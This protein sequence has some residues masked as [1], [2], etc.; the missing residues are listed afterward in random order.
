MTPATERRKV[1][2]ATTVNPVRSAPQSGIRAFGRISKARSDVQVLGKR[3][4][5]DREHISQELCE[6]AKKRQHDSIGEAAPQEAP[7]GVLKV[8]IK[9]PQEFQVELT[10]TGKPRAEPTQGT[11]QLL[12][13]K[14]GIPR[15][16]APLR[17][18]AAPVPDTP[19]KGARSIL[20]SFSI[21]SSSPS[22]RSSSP[23]ISRLSSPPTTSSSSR[24]SSPICERKQELPVELQD[25]IDLH[26]S[27][28][29]ALSLHY[30]HHGCLTPV[31]VR[32]LNTS[33]STTW[34]KR[35]VQ[36][37]DIRRI[38]GIAHSAQPSRHSSVSGARIL[39]LT[40]YGHGKTCLEIADDAVNQGMHK[41][42]LDEEALHRLFTN[43][44][45]LQWQTYSANNSSTPSVGNFIAALPLSP[46][47]L[48]D[49]L[50][51]LTPLL[52]K[53][54]R[55][56]GDLKAGAIKAQKSSSFSSPSTTAREPAV[57]R[58]KLAA[59][60]SDGLLSRIRAKEL[61]QSA[62][63]PPPT[64]ATLA[65]KH[66]LQRIEEVVPV[67][68][69]LT[70]GCTAGNSAPFSVPIKPKQQ[71]QT[72]SFT[73]PTLVQHLQMSLRNPISKED[74][75]RCVRLLAEMVPEWVGLKEVGKCIGV[76]V[77]RGGAVGKG[78]IGR[79]VEEML[80][81]L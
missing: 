20:E 77:R 7:E 31:D 44:L 75:V 41:R 49:S 73:M 58:P 65:K 60:R 72:Q 8:S 35:S 14:Q 23:F 15:K 43:S 50:S 42:P 55:R 52:A 17:L 76:T 26:S 39:S 54:Q 64:T 28:L 33:V 62:L 45:Q 78:E 47:T 69:L 36:L 11:L 10:T 48:C 16:K 21:Q 81:A 71:T 24:S 18:A 25:L 46:I 40:D 59:S 30:A 2:A 74:A 19:T 3:K 66:A 63:P 9:A 38:L 34:R 22:T 29:S 79:R 57:S 5:I 1:A 13:S 27:F 12:K 51:K 61:V 70:S 80:Q 32:D 37:D 56:L 53:G 68:E 6:N 67:L 4:A